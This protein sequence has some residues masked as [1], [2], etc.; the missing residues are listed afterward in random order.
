[1]E[2][3][4]RGV[5]AEIALR[6]ETV[7]HRETARELET[8][9]DRLGHILESTSDGIVFV[10][11]HWRIMF[12]NR[13]FAEL[14]ELD[15]PPTGRT[16][17]DLFP[18]AVG[19][20]FWRD[21]HAALEGSEPHRVTAYYPPLERWF[22]ADA[23]PSADGLTIFFRDITARHDAEA[24]RQLMI[25]ELHHRIKNLFA[26]VSGLIAM[27][28]RRTGT[29]GE[30][31]T[32][33]RQRLHSLA[34]AHELIR[35]AVTLKASHVAEITL[36]KLLVTIL[37]PHLQGDAARVALDGP[38]I[39]LGPNTTTS[40]ALVLHEIA[41]NAAKYGALS[42]PEG[43]LAIR[44]SLEDGTFRLRWREHG[45]PTLSGSPSQTGFGAQLV[46][47]SVCTQMAGKVRYAWNRTGLTIDI[48]IPER[49][50]AQ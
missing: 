28:A 8:T 10:D 42:T 47:M 20:D 45:G 29:P 9:N 3:V 6:A 2:D 41:T 44:W 22:E 13:R 5:D 1:M 15:E 39:H 46:N 40:F 12:A 30:M 4:A 27:T 38:S 48:D 31:A 26:I 43:R 35:P 17:W 37:E 14:T 18:E 32:S 19:N 11:A 36:Q 25:R 49:H 23:T 34:R 16:L 50:F 21:Y 7:R 33:L 24:A